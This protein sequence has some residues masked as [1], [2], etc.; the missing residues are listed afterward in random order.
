MTID[1]QITIKEEDQKLEELASALKTQNEEIVQINPKSCDVPIAT[2]KIER[3]AVFNL[4][5]VRQ[6]LAE[7]QLTRSRGAL[8]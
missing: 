8:T 3:M 1:K 6:K 2:K 4:K 7:F 5:R